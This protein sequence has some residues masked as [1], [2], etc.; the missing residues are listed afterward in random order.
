MLPSVV[1]VGRPNVGKSTL[2]NLIVGARRSIT[3]DEPGITRDRIHGVAEHRGRRFEI[4]DTGGLLPDD[5][6]IIPREIFRQARVALDSAAYAIFL[7]DGRAGVTE[8][9]R[10]LA[11][12]L[13]RLRLPVAVAVNKIDTPS[14][15]PLAHEFHALGFDGVF[16]VSAEHRTGVDDL[17]DRVVA[18]LPAGEYAPADAPESIRVAIIGRPNVGKST[19]LNK[20]IGAERAIVSPVAGT[21]R[22][23]VDERIT[24]DGVE[25]VFVDTAGIR[26]KGKTRRMAEKLS[27]VMARKHIETADAALVLIDALEGPVALDANIAGYAHQAGRP[28]VLVVNKWDAAEKRNKKEF[29]ERVRLTM[30]FLEYAPVA[31]ASALT[32]AGVAQLFGLVR[33]GWR[34]AGVRVG[35]GEL[36]R[37]LAS[38]EFDRDVKV[39]YITQAGVHPPTFVVFTDGRGPLHFAAERYLANRLRERFGFAGSPLV[40]KTRSRTRK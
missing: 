21:T 28:P 34:S 14:S 25:Y 23:A 4:V 22:D 16:P 13:R 15:E 26:R 11:G 30:K 29:V 32:G 18:A 31:F 37:F 36:N 35:T 10:E 27:V 2:F 40:V 5:P 17:L 9:D 33:R 39:K 8:A 3:G 24:R 12:M 1:I 38:L 7:V 6:D 20:L 19:L